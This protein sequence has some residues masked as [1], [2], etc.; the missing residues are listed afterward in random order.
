M[1]IKSPLSNL[2]FL[3][4]FA[5]STVVMADADPASSSNSSDDSSNTPSVSQTAS[6]NVGPNLSTYSDDGLQL[7]LMLRNA[8]DADQANS[9][10]LWQRIRNGYGMQT[11]NSPYTSVH[12]SW[13]AARPDYVKRMIARSKRYLFHVVEEVQKRGMPTEVAL[14][15]M[16]ESAFNPVAYSTSKASGIWQFVP[17]TGR[18]FGLKQNWWTDNRRDVTAATNAALNYLEKLHVMFGTWELALAAYN[19]GEGTVQRAIEYNRRKGLPTDYQSLPLPPETR[20]YVPKLQAVKNIVDNPEQYGLNIQSIPDQPYFTKVTAPAK[21][22]VNLAAKLAGVSVEEFTSLNP[23]SNRPILASKGTSQEIL[24]PV[25]KD[26]EFE[27]NLATYNKPLVSW[28][29]YETK[30]GERVDAIASKFGISV[31]EL[32]DVN[33]LPAKGRLKPNQALLVPAKGDVDPDTQLTL[34]ENAPSVE[35][36]APAVKTTKYTV[37]KGDNIPG[38]AK[39]FGMNPK[40]LMAMNHLNTG[41]KLK[42]GQMLA[43]TTMVKRS[44]KR[45]E[46]TMTAKAEKPQKAAGKASKLAA[47]KS[48][49]HYTVKRGETIASIAKKFKVETSDLQRWN[50]LNGKRALVPGRTLVIIKEDA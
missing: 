2:L 42:N 3:A 50:N 23:A 17:A 18:N 9:G 40:Q 28:Q 27:A 25:G 19:A 16:V 49:S 8:P 5:S 43:V 26:Q 31:A 4:L 22:D 14:L 37:H 30:R 35:P 15:P 13:Y 41:S 21:I 34:V 10:D 1:M 36:D 12:E 38:I 20:N 7:D 45:A 24:L 46:K 11:L 29:T 33:D 44:D 6:E 48:K 47:A 32:R 39:R